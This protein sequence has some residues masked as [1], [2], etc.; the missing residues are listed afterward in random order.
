MTE[1]NRVRIT[2]SK[3]SQILHGCCQEAGIEF[4][5][6]SWYESHSNLDELLDQDQALGG[7]LF[8]LYGDNLRRTLHK[9]AR[10]YDQGAVV[11]RKVDLVLDT[12][13][14]NPLLRLRGLFDWGLYF[15][16][17]TV[18]IERN[19]NT[20][21]GLGFAKAIVFRRTQFVSG[22]DEQR[23]PWGIAHVQAT[24]LV[25]LLGG[26]SI[27][28]ED[29]TF[30]NDHIQVRAFGKA[31]ESLQRMTETRRPGGSAN[32]TG[33]G[34]RSPKQEDLGRSAPA[35]RRPGNTR[36]NESRCFGIGRLTGCTSCPEQRS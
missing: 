1:Q 32:K 28:F 36:C 25:N 14:W 19:T 18:R 21:L 35:Q 6:E 31:K 23:T 5:E 13:N 10:F 17:C 3:L 11:V 8:R 22:A 24:W 29:C 2:L 9:D 33:D 12:T 4:D 27:S 30:G 20:L 16:E 26:S 7:K 15:E 34:K